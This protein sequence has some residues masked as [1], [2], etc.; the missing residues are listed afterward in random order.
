MIRHIARARALRQLENTYPNPRGVR[1]RPFVRARTGRGLLLAVLLAA[2]AGS[3]TIWQVQ[4]TETTASA[5]L[6]DCGNGRWVSVAE[7]CR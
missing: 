6:I 4:G 3:L 5:R 7:R 2:T 1:G